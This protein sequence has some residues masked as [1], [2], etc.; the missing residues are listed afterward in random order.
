MKPL[1]AA[2]ALAAC[3]CAQDANAPNYTADGIVNGASFAP[4]LAPNTIVSIFGTN[5]SWQ[6]QTVQGGYVS[7]SVMPTNLA[8]VQVY[9]EGWPAYLYYVSPLQINLLVPTSLVPGNFQLWVDRQGTRGPMVNVTLQPAAPAMFEYPYGT[10]I[11]THLDGSLCS[12]SAPAAAGEIV[13]LWATGL[14]ETYP[15][16]Q[17]GVLPLGAQSLVQMSAFGVWIGGVAV[18]PSAILYAGVAPGYAGLYQVN[19]KLPE[20]LAPN[21]EIR[22][23]LSGDLSPAG[24]VLPAQ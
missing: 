12:A 18:D 13:S 3:L 2:L 4:G 8:G 15:K 22:F 16:L 19:L 10:A 21:P 17:D 24:L 7:G 14:G 23:G 5:L 1:F 9:F 6:T 11:A 20:Q